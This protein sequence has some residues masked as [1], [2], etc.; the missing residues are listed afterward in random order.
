MIYLG[1][2]LGVERI[3][4]ALDE[5]DLGELKTKANIK[6]CRDELHPSVRHVDTWTLSLA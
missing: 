1:W 6:G 5:D 4:E 2:E 3:C